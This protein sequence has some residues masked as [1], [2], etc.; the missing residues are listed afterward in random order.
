[1]TVLAEPTPGPWTGRRIADVEGTFVYDGEVEVHLHRF[2]SALGR[3]P[4]TPSRES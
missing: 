1:L 4:R 2:R 3:R